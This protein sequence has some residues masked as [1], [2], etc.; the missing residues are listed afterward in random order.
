MQ[1]S[2]LRIVVVIVLTALVHS[3]L[4]AQWVR[5][6]I[7]GKYPQSF[8]SS[9]KNLC[10]GTADSGVFVSTN[11]GT[12]WTRA[13][14]GLSDT[15]VYSLAVTPATGGEELIAGTLFSGVFLS[16]DYGA[17]W[18]GA[19]PGGMSNAS[20]WGLAVV[21]SNVY[22]AA[23][24]VWRSTDRGASWSSMGLSWAGV[25]AVAV[26]GTDLFAGTY[27]KGVFR[28]T[29]NGATWNQASA[30]MT[31]TTVIALAVSDSG[32][33][34][35]TLGGGVYF[36][37]DNGIGWTQA[38]HGLTNLNI[39]SL[40]A[41][42]KNAFAGTEAGIFLSTDNGGSW[43]DV[44]GDL[45]ET[46]INGLGILPT[47]VGLE[48]FAGTYGSGAWQ[49]PIS[50]IITSVS[51]SPGQQI[52]NEYSLGQNFPNP[53]NPTTTI[54][55]SIPSRAFVTLRIYDILGVERA[56]LLSKELPGGT[57]RVDWHP[58]A[59]GS[60]VY[61]YRLQAG[62]FSETRKLILLK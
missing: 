58:S 11:N 14:A 28:S 13:N 20:V 38:N 41:L 12:G 53:F 45:P 19:S 23:S 17:S 48:L 61:F 21:D 22:A 51:Q 1:I 36:S 34:A 27:L 42:G 59:D 62:R 33:F 9:G 49:R 56:T 47:S 26:S 10:I 43:S 35:G 2:R 15:R 24:N 18:I 40:V 39:H 52:P 7:A 57:H 3:F 50:G 46:R 6:N 4:S 55:F 54:E 16:T 5:T 8:A 60:G 37:P 31:D 32:I 25:Y 29:D 30:G 44:T